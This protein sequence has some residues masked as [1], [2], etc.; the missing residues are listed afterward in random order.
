MKQASLLKKSVLSIIVASAVTGS[1]ITLD[2]QQRSALTGNTLIQ[3]FSKN[4]DFPLSLIA[5]A[6]TQP[7]KHFKHAVDVSEVL[8]TAKPQYD[9]S[10]ANE[11]KQ[12]V[13]YEMLFAFDSIEIEASYYAAL[14][15][16]AV[17]LKAASAK[18]Q[19]IWQVIGYADAKG[20]TQYNH[21]LAKKRAQVVADFLISK[22]VDKTLLSVVSLGE[23]QALSGNDKRDEN[24][25]RRVEIHAYQAE[26]A[27]LSEQ[28]NKKNRVINL[29]KNMLEKINAQV[30][31]QAQLSE[32][33]KIPAEKVLINFPEEAMVLTTAMEF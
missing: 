2:K 15:K 30:F 12:P 8:L 3:P 31:T 23:S 5:Q 33:N 11:N 28:L 21:K 14:Y 9:Q 16:T 17:Q 27:A 20:N 10:L 24:L 18:G 25:Q 13:E 22:G 26:I 4:A 7:E 29:S 32:S 6:N 19:I 1:L